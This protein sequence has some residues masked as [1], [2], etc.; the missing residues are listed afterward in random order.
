MDDQQ[1]QELDARLKK[2]FD[3]IKASCSKA[4]QRGRGEN[5]EQVADSNAALQDGLSAA[6]A[7]ADCPSELALDTEEVSADAKLA[8]KSQRAN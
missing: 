7:G 4:R 5:D 2:A 1:W 8:G 6:D 3:E